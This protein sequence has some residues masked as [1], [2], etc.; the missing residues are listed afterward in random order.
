MKGYEREKS[1]LEQFESGQFKQ[2]NGVEKE[3]IKYQQ[4]AKRTMS[5][6]VFKRGLH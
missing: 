2:V 1:I 5:S 3:K 6:R 4:Y